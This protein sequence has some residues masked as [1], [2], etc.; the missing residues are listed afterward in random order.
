M[1][2]GKIFGPI[3]SGFLVTL[4]F[5]FVTL[6][7][8]IAW[9]GCAIF[10]RYV[11]KFQKF[12]NLSKI[13]SF[14]ETFQRDP[15]KFPWSPKKVKKW[16]CHLLLNDVLTNR[17]KYFSKIPNPRFLYRISIERSILRLFK[18]GHIRFLS[19]PLSEIRASKVGLVETYRVA[20]INVPHYEFE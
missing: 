11:S 10:V 14:V 18:S 13:V 1:K 16:H 17:W 3:R 7:G 6:G 2:S 12:N 4:I 15:E 20:K 9:T 19:G 8:S 5:D